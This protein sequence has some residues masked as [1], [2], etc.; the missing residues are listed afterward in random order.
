MYHKSTISII[1][2]DQGIKEKFPIFNSKGNYKKGIWIGEL[3]P[4]DW[5]PKYKIKIE[6]VHKQSPKIT[7]IKPEL[8]LAKGKKQLPHVY[9]GDKLCLF[10]PK[11][12]E[13]NHDKFIADTIIP[14]TSLWLFYYEG[15]LYTG[16][17]QGGGRHPTKKKK[18][19]KNKR[20]K[21]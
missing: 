7:V 6:Y 12:G 9:E 16:C 15:W 17:W 4:T 21:I 19:K 11:K 10:D 1:Q 5:S 18:T 13:W 2:Q 20:L 14:W 3:Q 8:I